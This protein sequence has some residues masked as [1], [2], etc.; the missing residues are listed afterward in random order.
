MN[1]HDGR[2]ARLRN[3]A[4]GVLAALVAVGAIAGTAALAAQPRANTHRRAAM[5]SN[6]T[7][8]PSP[9]NGLTKTPAPGKHRTPQPPEAY[10]PRNPFLIAVQQ[11]VD[12]RTI[13]ATQGQA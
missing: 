6:S 13:T 4:T 1:D 5:V 3:A 12:D 7:K 11:L 8:A 9:G 10:D 2:H